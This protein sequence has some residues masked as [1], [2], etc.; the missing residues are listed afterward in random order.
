MLP[1]GSKIIIEPDMMVQWRDW[2]YCSPD[3]YDF[4]AKAGQ[5]PPA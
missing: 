4:L 1:G 2:M 5:L 3:H